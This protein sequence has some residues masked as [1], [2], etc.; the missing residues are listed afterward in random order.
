[1]KNK[2]LF[3]FGCSFTNY[4]WPTWADILGREFD[5]YENWGQDGA[6]NQYMFN[7][8]IEC[9]QRNKFTKDDTIIICWTNV[10]RED[11]YTDRWLSGG[12]VY[13]SHAYPTDWV[14]KFITDRGCLI[15]DIAM[16]KSIDLIL[17]SIGCNYKFL[18]MVPLDHRMFEYLDP[19]KDVFKLYGDALD[20]ICPSYFETIFNLDWT[21]RDSDFSKDVAS[22]SK[23]NLKIRYEELAG[24]DW[25]TF[26]QACEL[27]HA[28]KNNLNN[29]IFAEIKELFMYDFY[30]IN[31]DY[32]PTPMEH[33]EYIEKIM[34]DQTVSDSTVD[35]VKNYKFG[36]NFNKQRIKRL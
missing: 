11:R 30:Q 22:V 12:N 23:K 13:Y 32:H 2:R 35:W 36:D 5:H 14:K 7:S 6:G 31:R 21:S 9:N 1:M 27:F 24:P 18:S 8:V 3:A 29:V 17:S 10:D 34:P 33:L 28:E 25:P 26:D 20:K 19:N 4:R 15:R 16:I